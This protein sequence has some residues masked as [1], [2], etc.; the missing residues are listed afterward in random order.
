MIDRTHDP[1][2]R[3][4]VESA[5]QPGSDFPIQNL[6]FAT[7]RSGA[8]PHAG[9]AI[10]D[11]V[12]DVT[13]ALR[14][15]SLEALMSMPKA[16]RVDLRQQIQNLLVKR[17][18]GID[19]C[20]L[21]MSEV[22]LLLPCAIGDYSDFYASIHHATNVGSMFRPDNPL[23]PNY[24]WLPVGYHGRASSVVVSG[25]AVRRPWGQASEH[26]GGPPSFGPTRRLDY[27][28]ELGAF[29]G[30]GSA[31]NEPIRAP[32]AGDHLFG[33]CLLNDWSARDLQAW[34]YQPLGPF[35]SK[36][37]ATSI[38]PW[39]VTM[40]ALEP[41]RRAPQPRPPS[42]PQPLPHLRTGTED[43]YDITLEVWLRSARMA[44]LVRVSRSHFASLYWTLAQMV[45]HHASNGCPLRAGDLIGSG[46]VSGPDKENRG[47]LL[48]L[49][50]RG[51]E[52]LELPTGELRRFLEDGDEVTLR[53]WCEAPGFRRIGLG[54]CRGRVLPAA[55]ET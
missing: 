37:F 25:T 51:S 21:P 31:P 50:W 22:E 19:A 28:L 24:K 40:E 34:E 32:Q 38:S 11:R 1:E 26:P 44:G 47:C 43:A 46:T 6:P 41:F 55:Q 4:W 30:P 16:A 8:G 45:A 53:G 23:L 33:V 13:K 20:M 54:E 2:L 10:G 52:P 17:T 39:V 49:T 18:T 36:S 7:F 15:P 29:L 5:N 3:S 9:V 42:D 35:L 14:I 12:L 27:E 48:E